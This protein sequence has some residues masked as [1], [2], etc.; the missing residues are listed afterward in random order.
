MSLSAF[1]QGTLNVK[2]SQEPCPCCG[3]CHCAT[4]RAV[5][6]FREKPGKRDQYWLPPLPTF[7]RLLEGSVNSCCVRATRQSRRRVKEQGW[8]QCCFVVSWPRPK[9]SWWAAQ[10]IHVG[11]AEKCILAG[12]KQRLFLRTES[13]SF[14]VKLLCWRRCFALE[15]SLFLITFCPHV[16][17][18]GLCFHIHE[19]SPSTHFILDKNMQIIP[20]IWRESHLPSSK[21]LTAFYV[22]CSG[23]FAFFQ[24]SSCLYCKCC[25][26]HLINLSLS[27]CFH[28]SGKTDQPW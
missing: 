11:K 8:L 27:A 3:S 18:L 16:L 6:G 9:S 28:C 5:T 20:F 19:P 23:T 14:A 17:L 1:G 24:N 26:S 21:V 10:F 2:D 7:Q 4:D 13:N 15:F 25:H 12:E 22:L